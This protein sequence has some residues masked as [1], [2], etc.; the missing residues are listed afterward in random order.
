MS[1]SLSFCSAQ[2]QHSVPLTFKGDTIEDIVVGKRR[3]GKVGSLSP[4]M[5]WAKTTQWLQSPQLLGAVDGYDP[6]RLW[7][8]P[9]GEGND[10]A[11]H[12]QRKK[13]ERRKESTR[14]VSE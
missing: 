11:Y 6:F 4:L 13:R 2:H 10:H 3:D 8:A 14:P 9:S 12:D 5:G 7:P 1:S